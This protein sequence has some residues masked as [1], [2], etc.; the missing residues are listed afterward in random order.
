[1]H[2]CNESVDKLQINNLK[3]NENM[4]KSPAVFIT[5]RCKGQDA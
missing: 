2:Q 1:M 3:N 5:M 4:L